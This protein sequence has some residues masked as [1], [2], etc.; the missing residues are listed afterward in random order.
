MDT[1]KFYDK[2]SDVHT[3][4]T[5]I[6]VAIGEL[7]TQDKTAQTNADN[8]NSRISS[9]E[10]ETNASIAGLKQYQNTQTTINEANRE[11]SKHRWTKIT[12]IV[13]IFEVIGIGIGLW[14]GKGL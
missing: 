8:L 1:D 9:F 10:K 7:Q 14:I 4:L 11:I 3:I 2:L 5:E 6:K 12:A 13:L